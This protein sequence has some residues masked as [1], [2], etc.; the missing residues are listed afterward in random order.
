MDCQTHQSD[1]QPAE[2]GGGEGRLLPHPISIRAWP[3]SLLSRENGK[4]IADGNCPYGDSNVDDARHT[5]FE[6][7]RWRDERLALEQN[8]G[9]ISPDNIVEKKLRGQEEWTKVASYA[10]AILHK[11]KKEIDEP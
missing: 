8:L 4:G 3:V 11:K 6:C 2:P 5:I 1:R 9:D 7:D 10:R